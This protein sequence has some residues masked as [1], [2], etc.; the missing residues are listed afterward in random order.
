MGLP[1]YHYALNNASTHSSTDALSTQRHTASGLAEARQV[2]LPCIG[3]QVGI[4]GHWEAQSTFATWT[5][6][7]DASNTGVTT[8]LSLDQAIPPGPVQRN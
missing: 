3:I 7:L 5:R 8:K 6:P 1:Q 4:Q 2:T